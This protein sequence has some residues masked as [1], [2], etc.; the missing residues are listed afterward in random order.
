MKTEKEKNRTLSNRE[1]ARRTRERRKLY[2][3]SLETEIA[4]LTNNKN[5]S[6]QLKENA[7]LKVE[8]GIANLTKNKDLSSKEDLMNRKIDTILEINMQL[9]QEISELKAKICKL[10]QTQKLVDFNGY[11]YQETHVDTEFDF[12]NF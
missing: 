10:E 1:S 8:T 7:K 6:K 4:N 12:S 9:K 5:L 3:K 2:I 11:P